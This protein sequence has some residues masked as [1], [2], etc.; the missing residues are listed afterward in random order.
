MYSK[1]RIGRKY[2]RILTA[3]LLIVA[4]IL[5]Q[6]SIAKASS[7]MPEDIDYTGI[8]EVIDDI[9]TQDEKLDFGG[10]V[11]RLMSGEEHF[12]LKDI[13]NR[14]FSSIKG[15]FKA[16]TNTFGRL[17]FIALIAAIFT[18]LSMAFK[19]SQVSETGYY[20]TYL[21]LF[22]LLITSFVSASLVA[23]GTIGNILDFMKALVPAYIIS[24]GFCTGSATSIAYYES[25]LVIISMVDLVIVKLII[26]MINLYLIIMLVNNLSKE[27]MLSR[28]AGLFEAVVKWL[29]K[30]LL[31][32]VIG[33]QAIQGLIIPVADQVKRN[34]LFKA[35]EAIPGIG[36]ALGSVTETVIGAGVLLKNSIGVAGLIVILSICAI[37]LLKLLV[38]TIIYKCACAALQPI[39]DKRVIECIGASAKSSQ[40]LLQSIFV[41]AAL[42]LISIT[43]VA[44]TTRGAG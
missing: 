22:G 26:P 18:N 20:V 14:L 6:T 41:G 2:I 19:N 1:K 27:D 37:P 5:L 17:I 7:D 3:S 35:S 44:V 42:F 38:I 34:A 31:A 28:L 9:M 36:D 21:L 11:G 15:E 10:Y 25:A 29:L 30:S 12:S 24:V 43:I 8:Q 33:F 40:M 23:S 39:S 16:G 13:G 32:A 4:G